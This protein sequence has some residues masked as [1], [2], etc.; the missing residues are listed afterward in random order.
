EASLVD[1]SKLPNEKVLVVATGLEGDPMNILDELAYGKNKEFH[2]KEGDTLIYSAEIYP[3][4]S[5]EMA[6]ILDE[7]LSAGVTAIY[8]AKHGVN[9]SKHASREEL[10][11][12]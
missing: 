7:L 4:R 8:S 5:R 10:K 2:I 12:M 1:L 3:G 9:V 6:M 11:F